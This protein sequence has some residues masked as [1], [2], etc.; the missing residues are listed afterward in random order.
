MPILDWLKVLQSKRAKFH[1]SQASAGAFHAVSITP[2]ANAC[3]AAVE[4]TGVR[5]LSRQAPKLPLSRCDKARCGCRYK[6]YSDRRAGPRRASDFFAQLPSSNAD[7]ERR[8]NRGRR[9][10]DRLR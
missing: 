7:E 10:T 9:S 3:R 5:F 4:V 1:K 6:H 2:G 8:Q